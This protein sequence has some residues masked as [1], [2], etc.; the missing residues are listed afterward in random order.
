M[1]GVLVSSPSH[2]FHR[3]TGS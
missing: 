3:Q 1:K 2:T